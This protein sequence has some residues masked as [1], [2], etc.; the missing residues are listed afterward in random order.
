LQAVL[1]PASVAVVGA[2]ATAGNVGRAV[3]QNIIAGGF[4]GVVTPVNDAGGVVC[5][6]RAARSLAELEVAPGLV[7]IAAA[8]DK[9]LFAAEAAASGAR[10]LLVLPAGPEQEVEALLGREQR[11]LE[12]VRGGGLRLVGPSSLGV[13]NTAAEVSLNATFTGARVRAGALAIGSPSGAVEIGLLGHAAARQLGVSMFA[14]L[15]RPHGPPVAGRQSAPPPW[16][17]PLPS[18]G[19]AASGFPGVS[20]ILRTLHA[21][22]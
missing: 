7:I 6:T 8:G 5:S 20:S 17:R 4:E 15:E 14:S 19:Q 22:R 13:L 2:A 9:V 10:A 1:A 3:L 21:G 16:R 11:L 18:A 12:V